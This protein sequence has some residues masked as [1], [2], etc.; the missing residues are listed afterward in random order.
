MVTVFVFYRPFSFSV[1]CFFFVAGEMVG[2]GN[3]EGQDGCGGQMG[4]QTQL[5]PDELGKWLPK[6]L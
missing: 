1:F 6:E 5:E 2:R 3:K 4:E